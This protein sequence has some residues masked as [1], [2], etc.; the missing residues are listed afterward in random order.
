MREKYGKIYVIL[1]STLLIIT[2]ILVVA[3]WDPDDGYKMHYPQLPDEDGWD[4]YSTIGLADYPQIC[5]ADDWQCSETGPVDEI[6]F[7][8]SWKNGI[9][10]NIL[11]FTIAI[12]ADIPADPPTV[13][14]SRP[15]EILWERTITSFLTVHIESETYQGWYNPYDETIIYDDHTDYYQYNII[16]IDDPFI[17][18]VDTIYWLRVSA[19]VE[20]DPT[21][22]QPLWGWKSS[23]DH[24]NDDACWAEFYYLD[25]ID[26]WEPA[27]TLVNSYWVAFDPAGLPL[28]GLMGGTDYYDDGT[29]INGWYNYPSGWWNIWF[30]DHPLD[31]NRIKIIETNLMVMPLEPG[32]AWIEIAINYATDIWSIEGIPDEPPLPGVDEDLFIRRVIFYEGPVDYPMPLYFEYEILDY[33]PEW[34]SIDVIGFNIMIEPS[35]IQHTCLGSLDLAFV[36]NTAEE[37][38]EWEFGDAPEDAIAY[39]STMTTGNFPTCVC[40]GLAG[41]VQHGS[42]LGGGLFF[43]TMKDTEVEGNAGWCPVGSFPPYDQDE[44][45][46]DPDAGLMFPDAYTIDNALNVVPIAGPGTPVGYIGQIATWGI[47]IDI[48]VTNWIGSEAYVNMIVDWNQN[49]QWGDPGEHVIIDLPVPNGFNGPISILGATPFTI[50]PNYGYCWV[51][52]TVSEIPISLMYPIPWNGDGMFEEGESEDYLLFFDEMAPIA[53][54][55]Y[56]PIDPTTLDAIDFTDTSTDADGSIVNWSWDFNDGNTSYAQ[57]PSHQYTTAGNYTVCLT[58]MDNHG[59]TN[60]TCTTIEVVNPTETIDVNQTV[61]D[62]GFPIRH[63][64]DGDW[65]SAQN[66]TNTV[67]IFSKAE[68]YMR[69][70]GTPEFNL[71]VE[72]RTDGPEGTLIETLIFTPA[73]VASS[74]QWFELDFTDLTVTPGGNYFI[75]C[76]PAPSTV[77]TS[78]GYEWGYAFGNHYWPGSFW[79]T[80]DGGA[81]WRDL[82]DGY[83]FVFKTY[84]YS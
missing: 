6:H 13:P 69:K 34:V 67:T 17:Q 11:G 5:L 65:G 12:H 64:W 57:H 70:F 58:V 83:E 27:E 80:R 76:P 77:T 10:G 59:K 48:D 43:G 24:W 25:W 73:V 74:W 36:I 23:E 31:Y 54:F 49:G 35:T 38:E 82:P 46:A 19:I 21:G 37:A 52:F 7:W 28:P 8:G 32:P 2:G 53:S 15:G 44:G 50:G 55:T 56:D 68:I 33:N 40:C 26:L 22:L 79:F 71:T 47:D 30:Y 51:R 75:V 72:L 20:E 63:T 66:F 16:D 62:R 60:T 81:L 29:S 18:E 45:F 61:F 78:F 84:G 9:E 41:W 39:P 4:V 3:D 42:F 1:I 14:Y